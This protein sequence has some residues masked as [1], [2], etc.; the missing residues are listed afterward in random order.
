MANKGSHARCRECPTKDNEGRLSRASRHRPCKQT[1]NAMSAASWNGEE[2]V[3]LARWHFD[4]I[5]SPLANRLHVL[6]VI[7]WGWFYLST[8]L[9]DFS[10]YVIAWKL[11]STMKADDVAATL[12]TALDAS[13]S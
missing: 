5:Q 1:F 7:D 2:R 9:D 10:R 11:R 13:G 8:V 6:K 4:G 3:M 12:K